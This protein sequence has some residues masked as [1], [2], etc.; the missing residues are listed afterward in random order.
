MTWHTVIWQFM[1]LAML[2]FTCIYTLRQFEKFW[3]FY[4]SSRRYVSIYDFKCNS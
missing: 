3:K 2:L 4:V 1:F